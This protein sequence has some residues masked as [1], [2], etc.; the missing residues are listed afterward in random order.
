MKTSVSFIVGRHPFERLVSGYRDKIVLALH[1]SYH[2][3]MGRAILLKY[4]GVDVKKLGRAGLKLKP[5]FVEFVR[6]VVDDHHAGL[7]LDMHWTP[8]YSFCNPCQV[9][10]YRHRIKWKS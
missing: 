6:S 5:T 3:N 8:V 9:L 2:E 10:G 7:E 1:G 4:R